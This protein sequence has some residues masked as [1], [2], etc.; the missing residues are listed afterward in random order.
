MHTAGGG[1]ITLP[2]SFDVT[3]KGVVDKNTA[4]KVE[5]KVATLKDLHEG[6]TITIRYIQPDDG[7]SIQVR[8]ITEKK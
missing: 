8:E 4:I 2:G 1:T 7:G 5:G 3:V 6:D